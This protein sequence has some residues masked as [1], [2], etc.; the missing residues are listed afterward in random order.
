MITSGVY[1]PTHR[2][3]ASQVELLGNL[4]SAARE[5]FRRSVEGIAVLPLVIFVLVAALA[6]E[7]GLL[8]H[9]MERLFLDS[10]TG[11]DHSLLIML[12]ALS[13]FI[14]IIA[15][16]I[17][18]LQKG[19]EKLNRGMMSFGVVALIIFLLGFGLILSM[20][21]FE[22]SLDYFFSGGTGNQQQT[23]TMAGGTNEVNQSEAQAKDL[24]ESYG[25]YGKLTALTLV[26]IGLGC[27][28]FLTILVSH[29]LIGKLLQ[30]TGAYL[31]AKNK[32]DQSNE[33]KTAILAADERLGELAQ[34]LEDMD[35]V[36]PAKAV[37]D[38][39]NKVMSRATIALSHPR[40]ILQAAKLNRPDKHE[41][42]LSGL[43]AKILG[44]PNESGSINIPVLEDQINK[45][46]AAIGEDVIH[47]IAEEEAQR[48]LEANNF[49]QER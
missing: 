30:L 26:S 20:S 13:S 32:Y 19:G 28:F 29:F 49:S 9:T 27:V 46:D 31:R 44:I 2:L 15:L 5:K 10:G 41:N 6:V 8:H 36:T 14:A 35:N 1:Y 7:F 24:G 18:T 39:A 38:A 16:H 25:A 4:H 3:N 22:T 11:E 42:P 48:E 12:L 43:G 37:G 45:I 21:N 34:I 47:Q 23:E 33:L 40:K 17:F